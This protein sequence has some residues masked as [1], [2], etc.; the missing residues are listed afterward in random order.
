[1][2]EKT[3]LTF[4]QV[5]TALNK[6]KSTGE[7]TIQTTNRFSLITIVNWALYQNDTD[8]CNKQH[9]TPSNKQITNHQQA[10]NKQITTNKNDKNDKNS[11]MEEKSLPPSAGLVDTTELRSHVHRE[12]S[13]RSSILE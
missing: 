7:I 3:G 13:L 8:D 2:S 9:N 5:R 10:D 6:L 11:K 12:S 1:L 4:Q